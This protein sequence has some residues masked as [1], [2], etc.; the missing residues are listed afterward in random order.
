MFMYVN[1]YIYWPC[2][3]IDNHV[4]SKHFWDYDRGIKSGSGKCIAT[5]ALEYE[6]NLEYSNLL[7]TLHISGRV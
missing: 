3:S 2:L 4:G 5:N 1:S 7:Q 6:F